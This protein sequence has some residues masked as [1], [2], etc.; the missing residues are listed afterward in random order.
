MK[1]AKGTPSP[2]GAVKLPH[3]VAARALLA[4]AALHTVEHHQRR[5]LVRGAHLA[6]PE[7]G[8]HLAQVAVATVNLLHDKIVTMCDQFVKEVHEFL[9]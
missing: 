2:L 8:L 3:W 5:G 1:R 7:V 9:E 4:E 6:A